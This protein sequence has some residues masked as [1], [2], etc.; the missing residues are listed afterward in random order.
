MGV[1]KF[2]RGIY[3]VGAWYAFWCWDWD[4]DGDWDWGW[5]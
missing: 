3:F 5:D 4:G 2:R 1:D